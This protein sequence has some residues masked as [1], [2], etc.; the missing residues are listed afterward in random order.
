[1]LSKLLKYDLKWI[2]KVVG[3]FYILALFFSILSRLFMS[4][5]NSTLFAVVTQI[6][7]G[8]AISMIISSL[9][10][11]IMRLWVRFIRDIY[12]DESYLTHTLPVLKKTIYLS[13][14]ISSIISIFTTFIV[15]L[16]CLYV[17][18]YSKEN[19]EVIKNMLEITASIY[20]TDIINLLLIIFLVLFLE[21][22]FILMVGYIG[23]IIGHKSNK[24]K[25]KKTLITSFTLYILTQG[26][27][28]LIIFIIALFNNDIMN[29]IN[30]SDAVD[31]K[32]IKSIMNISILIYV[33]YNLMYYF[34]GKWQFE[35][36][37]N[38]D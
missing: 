37:V 31:I 24:N 13:K 8:F 2:Y 10:N 20:N 7:N 34:I 30:T 25:M 28:L 22:M 35:K 32:T 17:C 21:I 1:M 26:L 12:K 5:D 9:I 11:C 27:T 15:A 36:G 3:I 29:L 33:I 23:I 4:I 16:V 19:L 18:Y 38:V 14:I 6:T